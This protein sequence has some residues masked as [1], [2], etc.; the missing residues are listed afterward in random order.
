MGK[1][2]KNLKV[3]KPKITPLNITRDE[4]SAYAKEFFEIPS[5]EVNPVFI[6]YKQEI[7][8]KITP[9][10]LPIRYIQNKTN[11]LFDV[12][13]TLD[14]GDKHDKT[15]SLALAYLSY[16]GTHEYSA[17]AFKK[18]LFNE[19]LELSYGTSSEKTTIHLSGLQESFER[20]LV[21]MENIFSDAKVDQAVYGEMINDMIKSRKDAKKDKA[22]ILNSALK[23]Y[24]MYGNNS[25][26]LDI[27]SEEELRAINPETL[28]KQIKDLKNYKHRLTYYGPLDVDVFIQ[29]IE[30]NHPVAKKLR[31]YPTAKEYKYREVPKSEVFFVEYDMLQAEI[32]FLA[33]S[34]PFS[35]DL[36]PYSNLHN[37]Y[38]GGGLSSIVFQEIRESKALAY[39]ARNSFS[40]PTDPKEWCFSSTYIG[41]QADK[42]PDAIKAMNTLLSDM[43]KSHKQYEDARQSALKQ[44][45]TNRIV[46]R[47]ILSSYENALKMGID[48]DYR[49]NSYH[50]LSSMT[51]ADLDQFFKTYISNKPTTYLVI[52]KKESVDFKALEQLGPVKTLSLEEIFGY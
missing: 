3:D 27:L 39:S 30:K 44:M 24:G 26:F 50:K 28:V 19:G 45:A 36:L 34:T 10:G 25:E 35:L 31:D 20:G 51:M 41:T 49:K 5:V 16:L 1:E 38:F 7:T 33:R 14:M 46:K 47:G 40:V 42:L 48:Y 52:G 13:I 15:L 9:S 18:E 32:L 29:H 17:E 43:P 37:Q 23:S 11:E 8:E 2:E 4:Q 6:D 21:L 12:T 22:T